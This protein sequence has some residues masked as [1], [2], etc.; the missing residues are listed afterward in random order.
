M[1]LLAQ[2]SPVTEAMLFDGALVVGL[3]LGVIV[4]LAIFFSSVKVLPEYERGV[5]FRLGRLRPR[6]YGPGLFLLIPFV[7]MRSSTS[8]TTGTPPARSPRPRCGR[9]SARSRWTSCSPSGTG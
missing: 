1:M 9:S 6:D 5:V 4:A 3:I 8:R 2:A 7:G